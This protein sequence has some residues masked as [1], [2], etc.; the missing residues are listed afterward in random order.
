MSDNALY[1]I[2]FLDC[3]IEL[4]NGTH[5]G[6]DDGG[7]GGSG[8]SGG[9]WDVAVFNGLSTDA[10]LA[11]WAFI[12]GVTAV[13]TFLTYRGLDVVGNVA[14]VVCLLSLMPFA[15]FCLL[16]APRVDPSRWAVTPPG[17][18]RGVDWRLLLNTFFWN[19]NFWE[20]A[21]SFSGEVADPGRMFP[22]GLSVAVAMV[23]LS[24]FVPVLVGLG[25]SPDP[26]TEWSDGYFVRLATETVGPWLGYWMMFGAAIT[27]IGM[28]VAEM[29]SDAWQ[30]AGMADTP[31]S[32]PLP[33]PPHTSPWPLPRLAGGRHG[34]HRHPPALPRP[35]QPVRRAHVRRLIVCVGG[36]VP[37]L[38]EL[39]RGGGHAQLALL[40]RP[41]A[42]LE[43][44]SRGPPGK[45]AH[46]H[47]QAH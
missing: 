28:F 34:R 19:I 15:A 20:S 22:L 46:R 9:A 16:A 2:L 42:T 47:I 33:H 11:R 7:G 18:W 10:S 21:A 27:N 36:G 29:S 43:T 38:A 37:G 17:G 24:C 44:H 26:Y 4:F 40:L 32:G 30:V 5:V 1:P 41:G 6:D 31:P 14:I 12:F 39:Q 23:F 8:A 25:V 13:L 45:S 35:P 3:L